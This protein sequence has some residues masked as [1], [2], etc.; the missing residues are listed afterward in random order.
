MKRKETKY[1]TR[2]RPGP[3]KLK[4]CIPL[5]VLLR[6]VLGLVSVGSDARKMIKMGEILVDGKVRKDHKYPVGF[7]DVVSIPAMK[8]AYRITIDYKGLK[9]LEC[10]EKESNVKI[11]MIKNKSLVEKGTL[12]LNL[13]DGKNILIPVK[14]PK[15]PSKDI[16]KS[17]DSLLIELP[18]QKILDHFKFEK[19]N[20]SL[21]T[22]GQNRGLFAKIKD[23]IPTRSREPNKVVC[24]KDGKE[25]E[26]IKD[27]VF[28]VGKTK[29]VITLEGK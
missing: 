20:Y 9:V 28:I 3:H 1:V 29:P 17:G 10:P 4:N 11:S 18:S 2:P 25:F 6:D 13:H 22:N 8:K 5:Q 27:Y 14:N 7:M 26:A 21:M 16:Y 12:Q 19:G 15:K 23:I 24:E